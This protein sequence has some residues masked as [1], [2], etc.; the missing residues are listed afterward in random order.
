M[1]TEEELSSIIGRL[2]LREGEATRH[3][4]S[5]LTT[6]HIDPFL[7]I[8]GKL[9]CPRV[10]THDSITTHCRNIWSLRRGFAVR[11]VGEN[12]VHFKF[13]DR[14]DWARVMHGEPWLLGRKYPLVLQPSYDLNADFDLC[15]WWIHL[16]NGPWLQ[17]KEVA[18]WSESQSHR[19]TV[20]PNRAAANPNP[21]PHRSRHRIHS[22]FDPSLSNLPYL[23]V[24]LPP[25]PS[26]TSSLYVNPN[27][28]IDPESDMPPSTSITILDSN[29]Q[30]STPLIPSSRNPNLDPSETPLLAKQKSKGK[31]K[32]LPSVNL[33]DD[34]VPVNFSSSPSASPPIFNIIGP[35][36]SNSVP[37]RTYHILSSSPDPIFTDPPMHNLDCASTP[38]TQPT[39]TTTSKLH[40]T[41]LSPFLVPVP[42]MLDTPARKAARRF[43]MARKKVLRD[44]TEKTESPKRV[45]QKLIYD[46]YVEFV[47]NLWKLKFLVRR[48]DTKLLFHQFLLLKNNLWMADK[49]GIFG[50]GVA[51]HG[52]SGGLAMLWRKDVNVSLRSFS[53]RFIDIDVELLG[54]SIRA[55]GIYGE[56]NVSL[57]R[58]AWDLYNSM[59]DTS[60]K[61]WVFFGDFNE[62]LSHEEFSGCC[63]RPTW[64]ISALR[65]LFDSLQ[66]IDMGFEGYRY[67]W[68]RLLQHPRIQRARLD[69]ATCN[70][71]N[72]HIGLM[73][74]SKHHQSDFQKRI[75]VLKKEILSIQHGQIDDSRR[76][77]LVDLKRELD[78]LLER[79]N[80]KWKQRAK[81]HWYRE[82][83]RNSK[84]FRAYARK[85]KAINHIA[86]LRDN[87][88]V[89]RDSISD[90]EKIIMDY[91]GSLFTS[92]APLEYEIQEALSCRKQIRSGRQT[93]IWCDKWLSLEPTFHPSVSQSGMDHLVLV[94]DLFSADG[95]DWNRDLIR[96]IFPQTEAESIL[97]IA[98]PHTRSS[99][100]WIWN[101]TKNGKHTV[102]SAYYQILN[103]PRFCLN[104]SESEMLPLGVRDL[105]WSNLWL[106]KLPQHLL[107]FAWR[108]C[109]NKLPTPDNLRRCQ[110]FPDGTC[111]LC[112]Q[113]DNHNCHIFFDNPFAVQTFRISGLFD[114]VK[115]H[116]RTD[117]ELWARA[118][119][120]NLPA[121]DREFCFAILAGI[122]QARNLALFEQMKTSTWGTVLQASRVVHDFISS[123]LHPERNAASL[124][125]LPSV[126]R[127]V[128]NAIR[129]YFDGA[130]SQSKQCAGVGVFITSSEGHFLHGLA[131]HFPDV[132]DS[133]LAETLTLREALL[134]CRKI[135]LS[136]VSILGDS[137]VII[138]AT[139]GEIDGLSS[140][141][142]ILEDIKWICHDLPVR[143]L[144]WIPRQE[145]VIAHSFNKFA[146]HSDVI[147][148][149]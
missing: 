2:S 16:Y 8:I 109:S 145:N 146:K 53:E 27:L 24:D 102:R 113:S 129:V 71:E 23:S 34:L 105:V 117:C 118:L 132:R 9:H 68:Q 48:P 75:E 4:T 50:V 131:R 89:M 149:L 103:H 67:T 127:P 148:T 90:L 20:P 39:T 74:W 116:Q 31:E 64:Q 143:N 112:N 33:H 115:L 142:P 32:I 47:C 25:R 80:L 86:R 51:A 69:R 93:N 26:P 96:H 49:L 144:G 110:M 77:N 57:R 135:G 60:R 79:E 87:S 19:V 99:D 136:D 55:T 61:P 17:A 94:S 30:T 1:A 52:N 65:N 133:E 45:K 130:V 104:G 126:F 6:T 10:V 11:P 108:L 56:P 59:Y 141:Q 29:P 82:G 106:M 139:N 88:G 7:T 147:E 12:L 95:T 85:R 78:L 70:Q 63:S 122:W 54:E 98:I 81:Q 44:F 22:P 134:L 83:G 43:T 125:V 137:Q 120:L 123:A 38:K 66:L 36:S 42:M 92:S 58:E 21:N 62:V 138:I 40:T 140:Y 107:L 35:S 72:V 121:S 37:D 91:Y 119:L 111:S 3:S 28:T 13:N 101:Y 5:S 76:L 46:D 14:I 97:S 124:S 114:K 100:R 15:P 73:N 128:G 84:F 41:L 18:P